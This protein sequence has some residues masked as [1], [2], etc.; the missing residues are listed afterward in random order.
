MC[1]VQY[2]GKFSFGF[3]FRKH[4][5]LWKILTKKTSPAV[6]PYTHQLFIPHHPPNRRHATMQLAVEMTFNLCTVCKLLIWDKTPLKHQHNWCVLALH[7]IWYERCRNQS[8]TA[9]K[10]LSDSTFTACTGTNMH[11]FWAYTVKSEKTQLV[12][13][14]VQV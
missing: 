6:L 1:T 3:N 7:N 14:T 10:L 4:V 2:D 8:P 9:L 11:V 12:R 5:N 13:T